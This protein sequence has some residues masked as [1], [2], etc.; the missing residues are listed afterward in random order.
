MPV[1]RGADQYLTAKVSL[2]HTIAMG[3][4]IMPPIVLVSFEEGGAVFFG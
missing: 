2:S 4:R 1:Q 3:I